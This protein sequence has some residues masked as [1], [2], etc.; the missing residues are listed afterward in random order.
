MNK[1]LGLFLLALAFLAPSQASAVTCFFFSSA[2]GGNINDTS[3]WFLGTGGAC[4]ASGGWPNFPADT[5]TFASSG[6]GTTTRNVNWTIGTL[7]I[8]AFTGT[9]GNTTDTASVNA[10]HFTNGGSVRERSI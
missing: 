5:G 7:N 3:K 1:L 2:P 10:I 6:G 9:F 4:T 8:S